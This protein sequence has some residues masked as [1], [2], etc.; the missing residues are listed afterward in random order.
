MA[1]IFF[2]VQSF[3]LG[4][5][6]VTSLKWQFPQITAVNTLQ[7]GLKGESKQTNKQTSSQGKSS[8]SSTPASYA[9]QCFQKLFCP[10]RGSTQKVHHSG[11]TN[12]P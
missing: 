3:I 6:K 5:D 12:G 2:S 1:E 10:A 9:L 8:T 7:G 4:E 11:T